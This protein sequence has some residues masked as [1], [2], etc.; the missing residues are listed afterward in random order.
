[1]RR[2]IPEASLRECGAD[3]QG[4]LFIRAMPDRLNAPK[5]ITDFINDYTI[6]SAHCIQI[7]TLEKLWDTLLPK[8][9]SGEVVVE[10]GDI[11]YEN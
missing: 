3:W 10:M 7:R 2:Q 11:K 9:M 5:T 4:D 1:M 8:L 6:V